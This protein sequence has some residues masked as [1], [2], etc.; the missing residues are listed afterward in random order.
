MPGGHHRYGEETVRSLVPIKEAQGAGFTLAEI[1]GY[2]A[3]VA[4]GRVPAPQALRVRAAAAIDQID[5]RIAGL[6]RMR[7]GAPRRPPSTAPTPP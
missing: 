3:V 4:R 2:L 1:E 5:A 7:G 6:W